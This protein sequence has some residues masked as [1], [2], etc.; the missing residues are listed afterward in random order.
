MHVPNFKVSRIFL[1]DL[2]LYEFAP[3]TCISMSQVGSTKIPHLAFHNANKRTAFACLHQFLYLNGWSLVVN[4]KEAEDFTVS[5]V[6]DKPDLILIASWI[7]EHMNY[8]E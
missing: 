2:F 4:P 6:V 3:P 1:G 5:V 7:S 8:R